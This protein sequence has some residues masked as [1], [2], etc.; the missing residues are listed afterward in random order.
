M[1]ALHVT[2]IGWAK[3]RVFYPRLTH[4]V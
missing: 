4:L 3:H 1:T 2:R